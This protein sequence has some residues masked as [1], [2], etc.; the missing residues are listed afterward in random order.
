MSGVVARMASAG[1][2]ARRAMYSRTGA[3]AMRL[4]SST[5]R[6]VSESKSPVP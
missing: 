1:T 3:L 2:C 6:S 5:A 4:P